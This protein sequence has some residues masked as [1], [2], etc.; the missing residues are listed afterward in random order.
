[1]NLKTILKN[2]QK[3]ASKHVVTL[4][5]ESFRKVERYAASMKATVDQAINFVVEQWMASTGDQIV[6]STE[7]RRRMR[8]GDVKL[9]VVYRRSDF[10]PK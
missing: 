6:R 1:M 4:S 9:Q 2:K 8:Q 10:Q 7:I 5:D 3:P